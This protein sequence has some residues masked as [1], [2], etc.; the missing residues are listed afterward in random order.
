MNQLGGAYTMTRC[1][2]EYHSISKL[3]LAGMDLSKGF[4]IAYIPQ[5]TA[6]LSG[7]ASSV[8]LSFTLNLNVDNPNQSTALLHRLQYVLSID[9]VRFT[10]G[11][12]DQS[13]NIPSGGNQLLPL[14]IGVDLAT[15]LKGDSKDAVVN[16]AKNF[17]GIGNKPSNVTF[18]IKPTFMV[19]N[20]P[21]TA[22]D[23]IPVKFSFGGEK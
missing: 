22:P 18:H 11:S 16:I 23:Y 3:S 4:S 2:Y 8:P 17:I 20:V 1:K 6:V 21:V 14:T 13:L 9:E 5:L 15:L 12:L 7:N 19:G 10:S